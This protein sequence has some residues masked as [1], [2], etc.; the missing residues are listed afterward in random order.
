MR[1]ARSGPLETRSA[2][3]RLKPGQK[4]YWARTGKEGVHLG[5][6]RKQPRGQ[7][8]SGSWVARRYADGRY[9]T[10][11]FAEADDFA[12]ADGAAILTYS[13]AIKKLAGELS[14]VQRSARYTIK[15]AVDD[16]V[17]WLKLNRKSARD[18][19]WKLQHYVLGYFKPDAA[20]S[21][22]TTVDFEGWPRWAMKT[23]PKGRRKKPEKFK[24]NTPDLERQRKATV[25]R[26]MNLVKACFTRAF[27]S[28]RVASDT[29]WK[30]LRRFKGV[31]GVRLRW[32]AIDESKRLLNAAEPAFRRILQAGLLTGARWG[33]LRSMR[34]RDFDVYSGTVLVAEGKSGKPRRI[35]LNDEGKG[36]F[37]EWAAGLAPDAPIFTRPDGNP[38]GEQ[39][40]KRPMIT[41]CE[42]AAIKPAVGFHTLRHSYAS[43]LVQRGVPLA[44]VAE[45]L[46]HSDTRMVSKH[47]GHLS[48]SH[49]ADAIRAHLPNLGIE[50]SGKVTTLTAVK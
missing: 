16:Y 9:E 14:E 24:T 49:V 38:W 8:V 47:Y 22:L 34:A 36:A 2:R 28:E 18:A 19:K 6:R 21:S 35:P 32:L 26:V 46:G 23:K 20:V 3:L 39:D 5:Y 48:P 31:E 1:T 37:A 7:D 29:P 13:Q 33:E 44:I 17:E 11:V 27:L 10:E 50:L 41:A 43:A 40:Q 4:P 15:Q 25:N 30:R 42:G 12:E 45:A